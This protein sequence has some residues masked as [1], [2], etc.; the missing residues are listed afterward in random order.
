MLDDRSAANA[1]S[2]DR[3]RRAVLGGDAASRTMAAWL[4]ERAEANG[5]SSAAAVR[6]FVSKH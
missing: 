2:W 6:E 4:A 5:G 1:A 3:H